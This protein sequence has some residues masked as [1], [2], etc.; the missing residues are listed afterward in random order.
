MNSLALFDIDNTLIRSSN[1]HRSAFIT[2]I[3]KVYGVDTDY[4]GFRPNGMTDPQIIFE[5]LKRTG[6]NEYTINAGLEECMNAIAG[7][8]AESVED[9]KLIVLTGVRSLLQELKDLSLFMG[10]VTGNLE[11]IA[12]VK[13]KLTRL[14]DYFKIGG[15]GSDDSDRTNLVRIAVNR[16]EA[17]YN[18]KNNSN[19]FLFGDTPKD[20]KAGKEA[21]VTAIGVATGMFS[22]EALA[23]A[24]ADFIFENLED[25]QSIIAVLAA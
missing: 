22:K 19:V 25:K 15:F 14:N 9:E 1:A 7:T 20:I 2:G 13:L 10:L 21:G 24:D 3:K 4:T 6:I 12:R 16:A 5:I 11:P 17:D 18:F 23:K 8:F